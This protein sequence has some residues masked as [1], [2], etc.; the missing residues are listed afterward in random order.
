MSSRSEQDGVV[1]VPSKS[2]ISSSVCSIVNM[3]WSSMSGST[4]RSSVGLATTGLTVPIVSLRGNLVTV[5]LLHLP[6]LSG[7]AGH[8]EDGDGGS[9]EAGHV[10]VLDGDDEVSWGSGDCSHGHAE[11]DQDLGERKYISLFY[12]RNCCCHFLPSL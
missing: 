7:E 2:S 12:I 6:G 8:S 9:G 3:V 1:S 5:L 4:V 11:T 10:H